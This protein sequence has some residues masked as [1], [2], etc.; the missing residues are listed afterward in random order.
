MY[1]K[2]DRFKNKFIVLKIFV[3]TLNILDT[4]IP[5]GT[6]VW[7]QILG[8]GGVRVGDDILDIILSLVKFGQQKQHEQDSSFVSASVFWNLRPPFPTSREDCGVPACP[9][10]SGRIDH[11]LFCLEA[12]Y[13]DPL[14]PDLSGAPQWNPWVGLSVHGRDGVRLRGLQRDNEGD[15]CFGLREAEFGRHPITE[16]F[17]QRSYSTGTCKKKHRSLN[18]GFTYIRF[19]IVSF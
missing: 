2:I 5:S 1:F 15:R 7:R 16:Q 4:F 18:A 6:T 3:I 12:Y 8:S 9:P 13:S 10:P 19:N 11:G 14:Q 17:D